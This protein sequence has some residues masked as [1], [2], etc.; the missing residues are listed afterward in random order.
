MADA[1]NPASKVAE[2]E[3]MEFLELASSNKG[4]IGVFWSEAGGPGPW[5]MHPHTDELLQVL[6]GAIEIEILPL[7]GGSGEFMTVRTGELGIVPCGCWHR[8]VMLEVTQELFVTPGE[9]LH[10]SL[11]DPRLG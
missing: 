6:Q 11:A 2:L 10:S 4:H 9:T 7:D 5:E 8:H 3:E 1:I